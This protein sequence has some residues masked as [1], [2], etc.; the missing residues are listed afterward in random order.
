MQQRR[1]GEERS[2]LL[3]HSSDHRSGPGRRPAESEAGLDAGLDA[4]G[5]ALAALGLEQR[6]HL[7]GR[8]RVRA[9]VRQ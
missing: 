4:V 1:A 8:V 2:C 3:A 6:V 5:D 7:W 9:R